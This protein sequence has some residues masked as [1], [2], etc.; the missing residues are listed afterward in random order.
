MRVEETQVGAI[1]QEGENSVGDLVDGKVL[2]D[3]PLRGLPNERAFSRVKF[4]QEGLVTLGGP[5][6]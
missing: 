4:D 3:V 2:V 1:F 5:V 6:G